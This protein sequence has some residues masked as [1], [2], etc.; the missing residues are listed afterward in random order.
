[1]LKFPVFA[2]VAADVHL[3]IRKTKEIPL[4][5]LRPW[6]G[7]L[8]PWPGGGGV[9]APVC[10]GQFSCCLWVGTGVLG[11]G[12]RGEKIVLRK[13]KICS[14]KK[15]QM[16]SSHHTFS[17]V[18]PSKPSR[19]KCVKKNLPVATHQKKG[20]V[21]QKGLKWTFW[22]FFLPSFLAKAFNVISFK[23]FHSQFF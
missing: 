18:P 7:K 5:T 8:R 22:P 13:E 6:M 3:C 9:G 11:P 23:R 16:L 12:P 1:M 19:G 10:K 15:P 20:E 4:Q 17:I 21:A 14:L 2:L